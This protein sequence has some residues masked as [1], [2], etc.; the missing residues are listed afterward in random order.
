MQGGGSK[1]LKH[2]YSRFLIDLGLS[3]HRKGS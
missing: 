1:F 3:M 2:V